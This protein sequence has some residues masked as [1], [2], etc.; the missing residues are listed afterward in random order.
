MS[1]SSE[2]TE[3]PTYRRFSS[4]LYF[5]EYSRQIFAFCSDKIFPQKIPFLHSCKQIAALVRTSPDLSVYM[6]AFYL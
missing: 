4:T 6:F 1:S 2:K 5:V 3:A